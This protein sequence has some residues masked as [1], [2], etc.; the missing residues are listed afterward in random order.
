[1]NEF[2]WIEFL[3]KT[4]KNNKLFTGIGDDCAVISHR[5][6]KLL[7]SSDLSVEDVHFNLKDSSFKVIG[8]RAVGRALS[9]IA[10]CAGIPKFMIA[11]IGLPSYIKTKDLKELAKAASSYANKFGVALIGG[12][13]SKAKKL[14]IDICVLGKVSRP[15]LRSKAKV[16]DY[17][18]VTGRI[19]RLS[20][21]KS[22]RPRIKEA[23]F[24]AK[25]FK[26]N[27]MIDVSDG[28]VID[29][30]RILKES[31]K[32]A[33][34]WKDKVPVAHSFDDAFRGEDYE[35]IFTV[36]EGEPNLKELMDKFYL[37]G[38]IR[39][40]KFGYCIESGG[41]KKKVKLKGYLHF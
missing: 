16:G 3:R 33:I 20:F 30:Y 25:K 9:D 24:L 28:F 1:M 8:E 23:S 11:S 15:I 40:K 18:F 37:T 36:D 38:R 21:N 27:S 13:T 2:E 12:D 17:I 34:L 14:F 41:L 29:L 4:I 26:I 22:F 6:E 5:G 31:N 10:A 32:G 19:G 7:I 35:I 39:A